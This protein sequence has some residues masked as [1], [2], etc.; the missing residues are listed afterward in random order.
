MVATSHQDSVLGVHPSGSERVHIWEQA[1]KH[2]KWSL[3][4]MSDSRYAHDSVPLPSLSQ[5]SFSCYESLFYTGCQRC[6]E[7]PNM[8][9]ALTTNFVWAVPHSCLTLLLPLLVLPGITYKIDY[10]HIRILAPVVVVGWGGGGGCGAPW[11]TLFGS[12]GILCPP[13]HPGLGEN[14]T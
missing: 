3:H 5:R 6:R 12:A 4:L 10:C 2:G 7:V 11:R 14:P 8:V 13:L 9:N 1:K